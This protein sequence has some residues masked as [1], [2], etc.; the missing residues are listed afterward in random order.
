MLQQDNFVTGANRGIGLSI[1]KKFAKN[2]AI[3]Y[4]NKKIWIFRFIAK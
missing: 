2:G 1:V 4:A 3:V